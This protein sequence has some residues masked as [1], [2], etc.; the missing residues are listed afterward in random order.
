MEREEVK[1]STSPALESALPS[2]R[3]G[4]FLAISNAFLALFSIVGLALWGLPFYYDFM[5][6]QFGWSHSQVTSGNAYSKVA[7]WPIF[8]VFWGWLGYPF[9]PPPPVV[10]G[11]FFFRPCH[12]TPLH[13]S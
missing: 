9:L 3:T 2:A 7:V 5:V 11:G 13:P 4:P 6:R 12:P 10:V 8:R 1:A